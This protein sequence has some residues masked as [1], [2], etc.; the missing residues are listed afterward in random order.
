MKKGIISFVTIGL[1]FTLTACNE[2]KVTN[3]VPVKPITQFDLAKRELS[4]KETPKNIAVLSSG[5]LEIV[6]SLGGTIVGRP[7]SLMPTTD[8]EL[9]DIVEIGNIFQPKFEEIASVKADVLFAGKA[10]GPNIEK[11]ESQ[12]TKVVVT[13]GS[14]VD[15]IKKSISLIGTVL[16]KDK[17][18]G[19]L[20]DKIEKQIKEYKSSN[21]DLKALIVYGAGADFVVALP[22]S[23]SGDVLDKVGGTNIASD[24]VEDKTMPGYA[25]LSAE[26]IIAGNPD[27]IFMISHGDPETT[28]KAFEKQMIN[29]KAWSTLT[30]VKN[31]Q[32]VF[33]PSDLFA[34]NPGSKITESL[35]FMYN[36]LEKITK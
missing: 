10:F 20:T 36:E 30:A 14:S 25:K 17:K 35:E 11:V 6:R 13:S 15:D 18:A 23:L 22:T 19:E 32:I 5:E 16:K 21:H 7:T 33:L 8:P 29:N 26:R 27:V 4:F 28:K 2:N 24:F 31:N 12:G 9:K 34:V 3:S 1:A